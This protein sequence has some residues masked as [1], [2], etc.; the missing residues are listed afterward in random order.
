MAFITMYA[1]STSLAKQTE[2]RS[3]KVWVV[4]NNQIAWSNN[5]CLS[6]AGNLLRR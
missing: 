4:Q 2:R 6:V 5:P 1:K 3:I